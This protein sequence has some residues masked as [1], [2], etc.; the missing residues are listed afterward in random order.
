MGGKK[1]AFFYTI[2]LYSSKM[3]FDFDMESASAVPLECQNGA[4]IGEGRVRCCTQ[5]H[6]INLQLEVE[7]YLCTVV[8][9]AHKCHVCR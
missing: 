7:R 8:Y 9:V 6:F 2:R 3:F 5:R 1:V 4:P